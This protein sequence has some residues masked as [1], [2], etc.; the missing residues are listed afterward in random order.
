MEINQ[1]TA[2]IHTVVPGAEV[3]VDGEGC[4]FS[5]IVIS[6]LFE[7]QS[8]L[9]RQRLLMAPFKDLIASGEV[10][11]LTVKAYTPDQV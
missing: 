4:S 1:V 6:A 9:Q 7:G 10:H 11:A 2:L 5:I 8:L 3:R